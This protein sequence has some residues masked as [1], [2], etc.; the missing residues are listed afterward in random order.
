MTI[1]SLRGI[2]RVLLAAG[3][4]LQ[5]S[6]GPV[7]ADT[8]ISS[9]A[10]TSNFGS[11]PALNIAPGKAALVRLDL[12]SIPPGAAVS[13]VYLRVFAGTVTTAGILNYALVTSPW[14][15]TGVTLNTQPTV[16]AVFASVR[17]V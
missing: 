5:A 2:S 10:P 12:T 3:S 15:E 7:A 8:Y 6:D 9:G 13:K 1:K 17:G 16:G 4:L 11:G 14:S